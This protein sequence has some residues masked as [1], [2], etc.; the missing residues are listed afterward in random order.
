MFVASLWMRIIRIFDTASSIFAKKIQKNTFFLILTIF[1]CK[2][3]FLA[4]YSRMTFFLST[5]SY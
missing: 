5:H 4:A 2:V 1:Y 3:A